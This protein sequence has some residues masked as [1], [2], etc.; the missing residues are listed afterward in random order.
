M[1]RGIVVLEFDVEVVNNA[2]MQKRIESILT[3]GVELK[4]MINTW[5]DEK[6][7]IQI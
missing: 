4:Q 2:E 6:I 1:K 7:S 5:T 3:I